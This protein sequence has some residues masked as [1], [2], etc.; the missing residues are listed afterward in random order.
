M[1][2]HHLRMNLPSTPKHLLRK[3]IRQQRDSLPLDKNR[4][5]SLDITDHL[6]QVIRA[7]DFQTVM[8]YFSIG[9]EV[10]THILLEELLRDGRTVLGPVPFPKRRLE[11]YRVENSATD[12]VIGD[13]GIPTPDVQRCQHHRPESVD[14]IVVPGIAF[15]QTGCRIGYGAGYYDRFMARSLQAHTIGAAFGIQIVNNTFPDAWDQP[16]S[17]IA[18]E[19]DLIDCIQVG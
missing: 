6:M 15:D 18:T 3:Q 12:L 9:S 2:S 19:A 4:K 8:I 1:K 17:Q 14:C 13:F 5:S 7:R 16:V 10:M 11:A